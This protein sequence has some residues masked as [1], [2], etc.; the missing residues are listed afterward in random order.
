MYIRAG[1]GKAS[2]DGALLLTLSLYLYVY[3]CRRDAPVNMGG[4]ACFHY[5]AFYYARFV[6]AFFSGAVSFR[7][8]MA[9]LRRLPPPETGS[10]AHQS[11]RLG[12]GT[13]NDGKVSRP[14]AAAAAFVLGACWQNQ[15]DAR[16]NAEPAAH[17]SPVRFCRRLLPLRGSHLAVCNTNVQEPP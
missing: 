10:A 4:C 5:R 14:A 8:A 3:V 7:A 16:A 13:L 17:C 12:C 11:V 2:V 15:A 9:R 1:V 6:Y